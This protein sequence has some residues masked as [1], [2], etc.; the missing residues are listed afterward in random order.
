MVIVVEALEWRL[1]ALM[2]YTCFLLGACGLY[3]WADVAIAPV[4]RLAA[5]QP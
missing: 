1:V 3:V 2:V 4:D 5:S